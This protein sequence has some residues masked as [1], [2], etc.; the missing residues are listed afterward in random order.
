MDDTIKKQQ[1]Q[2]MHLQ[3]LYKVQIV[4]VISKRDERG[5]N[6]YCQHT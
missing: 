5:S 3:P 4:L 1:Q 6:K 2:H